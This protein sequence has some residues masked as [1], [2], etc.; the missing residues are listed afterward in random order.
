MILIVIICVQATCATLNDMAFDC[1]S[2]NF[3]EIYVKC[4]IVSTKQSSCWGRRPRGLLSCWGD[5]IMG[6]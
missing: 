4:T 5:G 6:G 3:K 2:P 1:D